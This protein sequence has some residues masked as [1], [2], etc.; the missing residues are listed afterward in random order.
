[1]IDINKLIMNSMKSRNKVESETYKLLKAKILEFKKSKEQKEYTEAE[2]VNLIKKMIDD[3]N[4]SA[5]I[6]DRN[7]RPELAEAELKQIDVLKKLLP[8]EPTKEDIENYLNT[9]YTNGI[10]KKDIGNVIKE[11]KNNLLG[12]DGKLTSQCVM[13]RINK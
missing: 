8:K 7:N 13:M 12:V 1:M 11:I 4:N 5:E 9:N 3:G 6:Y 2:E 10:E